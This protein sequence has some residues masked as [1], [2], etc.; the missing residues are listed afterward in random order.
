MR[1]RS[2]VP[3][4]LGLALLLAAGSAAP[5]AA[6][7][8]RTV[9]KARQHR[10]QDFLEVKIEY[11]VGRFTLQRGADDVL[12]RMYSKY[13]EEIF[14]LRSNY[15]ESAG[16]GSLRIDLDS[17][18]EVNFRD[19]DDYDVEAGALELELSGEIPVALSMEIGAAEARLDLG[20]LRLRELSLKTGASDTKI[21]FSEPNREQADFCTFKAGAAALKVEGLGNSGCR[22]VHLSG[23]V[24][25]MELDF[26]GAW[27]YDAVADINVGLGEIQ[28]DVPSDLGVRIERS[29]FLMA[30]DAPGFEKQD[31]GV[32]V[33]RNWDSAEHHLTI[34][35][36]GVLGDIEV[37]R[38]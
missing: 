18:D 23:G 4:L 7:T 25:A 36:S 30:F 10:G 12:Y 31:G 24:G 33:T 19:L 2:S 6:Q 16:E 32:W 15:L 35:I 11:G 37:A 1:H 34:S 9:S 13:D 17:E 21:Y 26:S 14:R 5:A 22:R 38:R 8:W 3:A 20:G 28:I 27:D 29:T